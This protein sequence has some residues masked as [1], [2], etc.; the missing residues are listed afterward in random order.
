MPIILVTWEA[1]IGKIEILGQPGQKVREISPQQTHIKHSVMV[2]GY[3][4]S[5]EGGISR[6]IAP[7]KKLET[8]KIITKVK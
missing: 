5:Y 6:R 1:G 4:P 7:G 2:Y 3:G 8:I